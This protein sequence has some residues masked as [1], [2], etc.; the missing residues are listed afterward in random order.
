VLVGVPPRAPPTINPRD[1]FVGKIFRGAPAVLAGPSAT[2]RCSSA[3]SER[4]GCRGPAGD[5][6]L[7]ADQINDACTALA[8]GRLKDG[9]SWC[10][11]QGKIR[12]VNLTL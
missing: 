11:K 8:R 2:F 9:L 10:S 12:A 7:Y 5:A 3:G 4:G 6:A 1:L